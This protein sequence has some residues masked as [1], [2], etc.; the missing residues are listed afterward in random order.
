M[1]HSTATCVSD[2]NSWFKICLFNVG[3]VNMEGILV[4]CWSGMN[5]VIMY[6]QRLI[7]HAIVYEIGYHF[8]QYSRNI[9]YE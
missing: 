1:S 6:V 7:A 3:V 9:F 5:K 2:K 8:I 4:I